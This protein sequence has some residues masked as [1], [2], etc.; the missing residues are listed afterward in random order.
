[1]DIYY[2][3]IENPAVDPGF[4]G[5]SLQT[6]NIYVSSQPF[7][8]VQITV[9][10]EQGPLRSATITINSNEYETDENGIATLQLTDE[11]Y[12]YTVSAYGKQD[13]SGTVVVNAAAKNVEVTMQPELYTLN[14]QITDG[15]SVVPNALVN[16]DGTEYTASET[17]S[18]SLSLLMGNHSYHVSATHFIEE[19]G[20]FFQ[21]METLDKQIVL[22]PFHKADFTISDG[23]NAIENASITIN[24]KT[25]ATNAEGKAEFWLL[26]G[27]YSYVITAATFGDENGQL[28]IDGAAESLQEILSPGYE[29]TFTVVVNSIPVADAAIEID[30]YTYSCSESGEKTI[31][32]SNGI[33]AYNVLIGSA[34]NKTGEVVVNNAAQAVSTEIPFFAVVEENKNRSKNYLKPT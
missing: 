33:Y 4:G 20:T 23:T 28:I 19:S 34:V 6:K 24:N 17:G 32:L 29:T 2:C 8:T 26:D 21:V 12:D 7:Y 27:S 16:I 10:D 25:K 3:I 13:F 22:T 18:L 14:L 31:L 30:G 15:T 9:S 5:F 1:M 11:S